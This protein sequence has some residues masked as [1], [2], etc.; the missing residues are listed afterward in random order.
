MGRKSQ[1]RLI[2]DACALFARARRLGDAGRPAP[3]LHAYRGALE[4]F[5]KH[6]GPQSLDVAHVLLER[7]GAL[8]DLG[9]LAAAQSSIEEAVGIVLAG[10]AQGDAARLRHH[11]FLHAGH[12]Q[13]LR[14]DYAQARQSFDCALQAAL[15]YEMGPRAVARALNG[16]GM[17]AK[18]A[19][20]LAEA[21][22]FYRRALRALDRREAAARPIVAS[23]F[24]NLG[25]L[26]YA[27]GRLCRAHRWARLGLALR[28]RREGAVTRARDVA[29]LAAIVQARGRHAEAA[30]LYRS[31]L[32]TL[33][34]KL[35]PRHFEVV[36]TLGQMA[37]LE[38]ARGHPTASRRLYRQSLPHLRRV[39]GTDHPMVARVAANSARLAEAG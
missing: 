29:A 26:E 9:R 14:A 15:C 22:D 34:W 2:R 6:L 20:R 10:P 5:R 31:A 23:V 13:V 24:H 18:H 33:T 28:S 27:R 37:A 25:G 12:V 35:G 4:L 38:Q 21:E 8:V 36:F 17:V 39:L 3:A 11:V 16:L 7:S 1:P 19:G 32:S 30:A